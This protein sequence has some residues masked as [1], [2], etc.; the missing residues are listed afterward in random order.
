M[1]IYIYDKNRERIGIVESVSS[2]QWLSQYQDAGEVKL[3]CA[4]NEKNQT[5]LCSGNR[6]Y[7]TDQKE[8]AIIT[9]TE[10]IDDGKTAQ[11]TV[12]AVLSVYRW[13]D[14]V[15]I[16]TE[17]ITNVEKG[18]L[19]LVEKNRRGLSGLTAV[20]SGISI[21]TKTQITW[22]SVLD[23][24]KNLSKTF[25]LGFKETFSPESGLETFSVYQGTDRTSGENYNGYFGDDIGNVSSLNI[26]Q[27]NID[28]KNFAYVGGEGEGINR[29]IVTVKLDNATQDET[30]EMWVD[31]KHISKKYQVAS[32]DE[33]GEYIYT[34]ATYSDSEYSSMLYSYGTEKL[35]QALKTFSVK[36]DVSQDVIKYGIDYFLGDIMTVKLMK[37][38]L[39]FNARV[40][41]V[42]TIYEPK[43]KKIVITFSDFT[44][45]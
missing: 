42:K 43:G 29:K 39:K 25:N 44:T 26:T 34:E 19:S 27:G 8:S 4:A 23:G 33:N 41:Q 21:N 15:V 7:C 30:K 13:S 9:Q 10:I 17:N 24:L 22:G 36:V 37:Y 20:P 1:T 12:R 16:A 18:M 32:K 38:S 14:R 40:I 45:I 6:I 11:L 28:F 5:L 31:A 3:V 35:L 2:L